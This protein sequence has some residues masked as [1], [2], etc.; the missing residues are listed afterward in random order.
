MSAVDGLKR[1]FME[2][3]QPDEDGVYRDGA[4]KRQARTALAMD[5][6]R[7]LWREA[8]GSVSF[9][10]P[11]SGV[12]LAAVGSL[13]RGQVGPSSDLDLVLIYE[14]HALNDT[15]IN[16]LAN[17]LW[18]P[19]W[20]SGLDLDHAVRTRAQCASVTDHDLPAA[21]GWLDVR[22][23]AGDAA[24]IESTAASILERWRKAARK[25]LPELL[26]SAASR[27]NEFGRLPYINQPDVKEARGGLRDTVL[28][29]ALAASWLADR[30]H[31]VYDE[32]VER[33]L[34][35]RD[36]I[37]LAAG[38]DTNL[39]LAPYQ[40][41]V[42]VMLGLA[43]PT[44]PEAERTAYAI[45]DLQ[46]LLARIGRRI[47]F[48]LDSTASRA[49]HS[50]V[51]EKPRFSFFQIMSPRGGGRREA[52]QFELVAPGVAKHEGELVLA[53]GVEPS[54]DATLALRVAVASGETGLPINPAT[55]AN[56]KQ[57]PIRDSQWTQE[58]RALFLRLLA[59]GPELMRVWEEID[60]VDLPGRWIPEWLGVRNRPSASAAH[61]YTIDRHSVEVV[62][63]LSRYREGAREAYDDRHYAALLLVGLLHDVGK[64]AFV[65]DHAAE[66]A[67]HVPVILRRMGF[68]EDIVG[69]A[70]LLTREHLTLSDFA[71]GRNPN[72]PAVGEE[73]AAR[74]DHDPVLLDML[75]DLTRADGSS[76]GA[77]AGES[78][79]KQYGWSAW[80]EKL[81]TAMYSSARRSLRLE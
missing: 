32:A 26:D 51:H 39:L 72:D 48:S 56:L 16:E 78:I 13:A 36:C 60:F 14:P 43:D 68:D 70:T 67:R 21:M 74:L 8:C 44:W 12:G 6:L 40:A 34:D 42:A 52:P 33:L 75:F 27:L 22:A 19:L 35:V 24:L 59:C 64:R 5:A 17:K 65:R 20:D 49:E 81:V 80:R 38:K 3:S 18:Y 10:V 76:L 57:C 31:G 11:D 2:M 46:T 15:Q 7:E 45:D 63:R 79:T 23:I 71:T 50:L 66:G 61:R 37:H 62:S 9:A 53:P 1:R 77:T 30:P 58:S 41:Q 29:S 55:L 69:W 73:L 47:A 28:V 4:A 25:R 54:R